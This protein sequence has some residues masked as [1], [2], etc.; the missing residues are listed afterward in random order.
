M[1]DKN[2]KEGDEVSW[3]WGGG[4][5]GGKAAKVKGEDEIAIKSKRGNTIKKNASPDNPAVHISRPGND[6]V[7]RAS[8]L[9]KEADGDEGEDGAAEE[10]PAKVESNGAKADDAAGEKN[11]VQ[12]EK[13][14]GDKRDHSEVDGKNG[15]ATK[16]A[17]EDEAAKKPKKTGKKDAAADAEDKKK[18]PGRPKKGET[19]KPPKKKAARPAVNGDGIGSRTRSKKT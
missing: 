9:D 2:I 10:P 15:D 5:P 4:R 14:A 19:S 1:A 8:E 18:G 13:K 12:S 17:G 7:K 11:G 16:E 6:V 3:A